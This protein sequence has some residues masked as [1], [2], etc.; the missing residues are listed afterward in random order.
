[1]TC[2]IGC[3]PSSSRRTAASYYSQVNS[4]LFF[5]KM[6]LPAESHPALRWVSRKLREA[7]LVGSSTTSQPPDTKSGSSCIAPAPCTPLHLQAP[8]RGATSANV[9][10]VQ[11]AIASPVVAAVRWSLSSLHPERDVCD[12]LAEADCY[13]LDPGVYDPR[14]APGKPHQ[15]CLCYLRN[16]LREPSEW[17]QPRGPVPERILDPAVLIETEGS[18]TYRA[19]VR[20]DGVGQYVNPFT[21]EKGGK[22]V[23]AHIPL[24]QE[25]FR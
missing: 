17:G 19:S 15:R 20:L 16:I 1:M 8:V 22:K 24:D 2:P 6:H 9:A 23:G 21:G 7:Q 11:A 13:G 5:V 10:A 12:L 3:P 14:Q 25:W 18:Q 4:H